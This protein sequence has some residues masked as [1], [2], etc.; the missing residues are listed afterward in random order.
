[1]VNK[2]Y[3]KHKEKLRK[4]AH[5]RYQNLSE[6]EKTKSINMLISGIEIFL[7]KKKKRNLNMVVKDIRIF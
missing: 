5:E 1:M 2:Y 6:E 4:E 3:Q 7:E